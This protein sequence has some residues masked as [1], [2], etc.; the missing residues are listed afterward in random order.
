MWTADNNIHKR[1]Q[2]TTRQFARKFIT[3]IRL[4]VDAMR[5]TLDVYVWHNG[6]AVAVCGH[7]STRRLSSLVP[8]ASAKLLVSLPL[9]VCV[10][11]ARALDCVCA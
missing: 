10:R 5:D 3:S 1:Q 7:F 8:V 4:A 6:L 11:C 2:Q 9:F